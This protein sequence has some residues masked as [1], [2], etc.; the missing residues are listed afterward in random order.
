M[1]I[2]EVSISNLRAT[3]FKKIKFSPGI[4]V[5]YG[6]NGKGKT[7]I[8]E[9]ICL[10][11]FGKSF[12]TSTTNNIIGDRNKPAG[13]KLK[14]TENN[15]IKIDIYNN[16][17]IITLDGTKIKKISDYISFLPCIVSSP[18][19]TTIEGKENAPKQKNLNKILCTINKNY[20]KD[21]KK[22]NTIIKQRNASLK[23][24]EN[25]DVWEEGFVWFSQKIWEQRK[26]YLKEINK[27]MKNVNKKHKTNKETHLD[28]VGIKT[29]KQT[30]K[31][32]I[33]ENKEKDFFTKK[34]NSGPHTDKIN[35]TIN[36]RDIKTKASQGE[37]NL[38]FS[39]LK[40]AESKII[41][42]EIKKDPIILLDDIFS[43]LD[44]E[45][46]LLIMKIFKNNKQTIITHTNKTEIE[47][48]NEIKIND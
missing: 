1:I 13:A 46:L 20:F 27:A 44:K 37:K 7:T 25:V 9:S 3:N 42:Q 26:E 8:L 24:E 28:I 5:L 4:N 32:E 29:N 6:N 35:Y 48:I 30:I 21:L 22:Y 19:E 16:K 23:N 33:K 14:T 15:S 10:L 45:N 2:S 39:I 41:K 11:S 43:K 47:N 34:T 31:Q 38:F 40:K 36:K 17:K 18:D 12:K